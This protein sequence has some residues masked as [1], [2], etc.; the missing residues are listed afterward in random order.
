MLEHKTASKEEHVHE[1]TARDRRQNDV[2]DRA[3]R[4][5]HQNR[6]HLRV[7]DIDAFDGTQILDL[8]PYIP[9]CDR[10]RKANIPDWLAGWPEWLPEQG[11]GLEY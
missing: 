11:L 7:A 9:V 8:K 3:D 4:V 6:W 5:Y 1:N 2:R 10:V